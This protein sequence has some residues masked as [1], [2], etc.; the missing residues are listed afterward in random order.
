VHGFDA[1]AR[2]GAKSQFDVVSDGAV[3]FS[4]QTEHRWPNDGEVLALLTG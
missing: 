2:R 1:A 3:V 4:K